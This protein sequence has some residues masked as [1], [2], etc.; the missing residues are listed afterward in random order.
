[1]TNG[2]KIDDTTT[3][4]FTTIVAWEALV[5]TNHYDKLC[6][7]AYDPK[8]NRNGRA[9][10]LRA[11]MQ[12]I[13]KSKEPTWATPD[14]VFQVIGQDVKFMVDGKPLHQVF[15]ESSIDKII[16]NLQLCCNLNML[17]DLAT[18]SID[19]CYILM[20]SPII[21]A[22]N[23]MGPSDTSTDDSATVRG[24]LCLTNVGLRDLEVVSSHNHQSDTSAHA[25]IDHH[26]MCSVI[27]G[28]VST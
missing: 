20:N 13:M 14:E 2:T 6:L 18:A 28:I 9:I 19:H 17:A 11:L 24:H 3:H 16:H 8:D 22:P 21:A 23:L 27:A 1:M 12:S 26:L 4:D 15:I 5:T 25:L 10:D 7:S